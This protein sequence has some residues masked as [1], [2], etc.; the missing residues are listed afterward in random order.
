M[1]DQSVGWFLAKGPGGVYQVLLG[2]LGWL[3][4]QT[5]CHELDFR[6]RIVGP[7]NADGRVIS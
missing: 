6:R 2:R 4:A 7:D 3:V 5:S 1:N